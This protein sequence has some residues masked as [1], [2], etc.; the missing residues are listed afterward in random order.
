MIKRNYKKLQLIANSR[1]VVP[2]EETGMRFVCFYGDQDNFAEGD[3][4][5]HWHTVMEIAYVTE[6]EMEL[7]TIDGA[8]TI[9]RGEAAFINSGVLHG[10][11]LP[12]GRNCGYYSLLFE[13]SFLSGAYGSIIDSKYIYPIQH[14]QNVPV[15]PIRPGAYRDSCMLRDTA[16]II[17]LCRDEPFAYEFRVRT[18]LGDFWCELLSAT[19]AVRATDTGKHQIDM[20]R[21]KKMILFIQERFADRLSLDDIAAAADISAREC[22][23]CFQRSI[24]TSPMAYLNDYRLEAAA[25]MLLATAD[26]VTEIS[27]NCGFSSVSYFGKAFR[28]KMGASP[29]AF[30]NGSTK[31]TV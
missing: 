22:T 30:R 18:L 1:E 28:E 24:G 13:S 31:G 19:E 3:I 21:M 5:W 6:G 12:A 8:I 16:E 20:D 10:Y 26:S 14:S 4:P 29:L 9:R 17:E 15:W 11:H 7:Q 2:M 25:E 23:R 27:E